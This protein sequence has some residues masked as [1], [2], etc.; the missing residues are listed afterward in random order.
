MID[1]KILKTKQNCLSQY[2][3]DFTASFGLKS[4]KIV[5]FNLQDSSRTQIV[6][7]SYSWKKLES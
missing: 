5:S 7:I 3:L 4:G 2:L 1:G 6:L